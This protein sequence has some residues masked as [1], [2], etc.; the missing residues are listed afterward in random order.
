MAQRSILR[1]TWA[2]VSRFPYRPTLSPSDA[3]HGLLKSTDMYSDQPQHLRPYDPTKL[4]VLEGR[5]TP[6][7]LR[8]RL[9]PAGVHALDHA[10]SVIYRT[11]AEIDALAEQGLLTPVRPY[12]DPRLRHDR[13]ARRDFIMR[14]YAVGLVGFRLAIR[15]RI[16]AFFSWPRRTTC[17]G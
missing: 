15:S 9:P 11:A 6:R 7:P 17:S 8:D 14:L 10:D 4:R 3:F 16:G 5:V 1:R 12:W 2:K 13:S